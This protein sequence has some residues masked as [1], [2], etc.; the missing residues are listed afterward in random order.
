MTASPAAHD[1][2]TSG[3]RRWRIAADVAAIFTALGLLFST[4]I[5][6]DALYARRSVTPAQAITLALAG[7][8]GWAV[9]SPVVVWL[10]RRLPLTRPFRVSHV[11]VHGVASVVFTFGKMAATG[12][13][14]GAAGF[15]P[16]HVMSTVNIPLNLVVYWAIVGSVWALDLSRQQRAAWLRAS[17][18]EASLVTA[19]LDALALQL[20]PHFLFNTLNS[21]AE[22]MH[23]NVESAEHMVARLSAL[24]RA[25][26]EAP[27]GHE[28]PL[29][30]ELAFLDE[31][32]SIERVRFEE[33]LRVQMYIDPAARASLV[34]R[35]LLQPIVE[36]AVRHA[37]APRRNGG[38]ITIEASVDSDRLT[39][40]V[41]D[42]GPGLRR[43]DAASAG[44]GIGLA[45]VRARLH[46]LY[47]DAQRLEVGERESG[48][49]VVRIDLTFR[50]A[51]EMKRDPRSAA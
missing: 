37:V 29:D 44:A 7:W 11:A 48:G 13:L 19:R 35:L 40:S 33:R 41:S 46:A 28:V 6:L 49:V 25:S 5:Y 36:N 51:A 20:Q 26:L 50:T 15:G 17:Q 10:A 18:L 27:A 4:Q 21:I 8:Y 34:P 24:L 3:R 47:G 39:M 31:Y 2:T 16:Q 14:L 23:E 38:T 30:Q 9:L 1:Q 42:D 43:V 22:L 32:L 12:A 45:N